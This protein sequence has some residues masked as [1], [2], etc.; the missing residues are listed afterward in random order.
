MSE[1]FVGSIVIP[2]GLVAPEVLIVQLLTNESNTGYLNVRRFTSVV[3]MKEL[4]ITD[5]FTGDTHFR[6]VNLG[7]QL[8]P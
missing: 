2:V 5:V 6:D 4:G 7:F 1:T 3:A 8:F